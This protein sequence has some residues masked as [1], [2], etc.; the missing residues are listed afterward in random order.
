M[1]ETLD[2]FDAWM[3][4]QEQR[5]V[6][7][8]L[9]VM[10]TVVFLDVVY[11]VS[12]TNDSPLV[13]NALETALG[14]AAVPVWGALVGCV[15]G[16]LAFRTRGDKGAEAKGIGVGVGFGAFI[17]AYVWLLPSGLVWSQTLALALTL[18]MGMAGACLAAYQRRHLA[19]DVGSKVWPE[20]L[21][22]KV[23]ALGHWVTAVFC[24]LLVV[25]GIRSIIG[26]GTGEMHIPGHF[27]TWVDSEH[28]A[29]TMTGTPIPKWLVMASIPFGSLVLAYRFGLQGLKVWVGAEKLGGDDTLKIL[30]LD[31]EVYP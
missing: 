14:A 31:E 6:G 8:M 20:K 2:R 23:A 16:V 17:A 22:P 15:L 12:A 1:I 13:P 5:A 30:G 19:L 10:G 3:Y 11:R 24:L 21:Q 27:D 4:R 18:W 25:L 26:V 9:A 29:G 7:A 28:A